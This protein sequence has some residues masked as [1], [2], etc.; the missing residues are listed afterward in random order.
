MDQSK[1]VLLVAAG[2]VWNGAKLHRLLAL[3]F[4]KV[5][6]GALVPSQERLARAEALPEPRAPHTAAVFWWRAGKKTHRGIKHYREVL[7][8][9][10]QRPVALPRLAV[11]EQASAAAPLQADTHELVLGGKADELAEIHAGIPSP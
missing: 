2:G 1:S 10:R 5:V 3:I 11:L 6:G 7:L 9:D 4:G 8:R